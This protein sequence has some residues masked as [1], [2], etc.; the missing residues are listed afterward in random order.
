MYRF[1]LVLLILHLSTSAVTADDWP[2]FRGP[3]GL[4]LSPEKGLPATWSDNNNLSWKVPLPG[5][6]ASSP[7]VLGD[8]I[9]LTCYSGYGIDREANEKMDDL[10]LHLLCLQLADGEPIWS[11]TIMPKLPESERVRDHGYAAATPVT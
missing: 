10:R 7:I 11:E 3:D 9:Y 8:R 6:G 1:V 5:Y 4:G 2:Q